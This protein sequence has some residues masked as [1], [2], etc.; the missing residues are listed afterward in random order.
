M[1]FE[2]SSS[3]LA[4]GLVGFSY[5]QKQGGSS[6][7]TKIQRI[8][9]NNGLTVKEDG[10]KRNMQLLRRSK[11]KDSG[12]VAGVEYAYRIPLGLSFKDFE[13]KKHYIQDGINN[14]QTVLDITFQDLKTLK[15]D[16]DIIQSIKTLLNKK[17]KLRKEIELSYDGV[18]KIKVFDE[19]LTT[20]FNYQEGMTKGWAV[21]VGKSRSGLITHDFE[22]KAHIIV[23]GTTDF[24]K[25][26]WVNSTINTLLTNK[27]ED[28]T[29]TLIDLKGGLEFNRYRHLKQVKQYATN[30]E[31]A[32]EALE[33][34]VE[35][36]DKVTEYL[37]EKGFSNVKEAG[38]KERHFIV[39]DEAADMADD[40]DCQEKLK[41]IARKGRASGLRLIYT[42]QY[43]TTETVSSQVKRNCIGRLCFV[44]DTSTASQVVLDQGGAEKL[45]PI[46]GRALYKELG[47]IEVQTPLITNDD[48]KNIIQP[49]INIRPRKERVEPDE[50]GNQT[51][52]EGR[53]HSLIIK[54]A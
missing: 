38:F 14:K 39:I 17:K 48:I 11:I 12:K 52:T 36:M 51:A 35:Q 34:A 19:P 18:L 28:V 45:P 5:L 1:L 2:I 32:K 4:G 41:D 33:A 16:R 3:I 7:A 27:G 50:K 44:L 43:P 22:K 47:L 23:A 40:K 46:Q 24:G 37:L 6:D 31:E 30:V 29:F 15:L 49:H 9:A 53:K 42:T 21:P 10:Q 20:K 26:N 25:S 54:K 8:C 13:D